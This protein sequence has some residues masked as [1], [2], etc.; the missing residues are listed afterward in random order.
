MTVKS[1]MPDHTLRTLL[2]T[3]L[4]LLASTASALEGRVVSVEPGCPHF[5]VETTDGFNVFEHIQGPR[6]EVGDV[7]AGPL[8]RP[9]GYRVENLR[10]RGY[11]MIYLEAGPVPRSRVESRIPY[12]CKIHRPDAE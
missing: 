12:K 1:T 9:G 7:I 6:P 10:A 11:A 5:V 8:D 3:G 2:V 4:W